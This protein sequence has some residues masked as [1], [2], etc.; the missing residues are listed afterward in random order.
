[1]P[2]VRRGQ[3]DWIT[4]VKCAAELKRWAFKFR[5]GADIYLSKD[6]YPEKEKRATAWINALLRAATLGGFDEMEDLIAL[7]HSKGHECELLLDNIEKHF[8]EAG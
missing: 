5:I 3:V 4:P 8:T 2:A 7:M 6:V 1:M